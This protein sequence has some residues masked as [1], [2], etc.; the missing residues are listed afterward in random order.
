MERMKGIGPSCLFRASM[1]WMTPFAHVFP[2]PVVVFAPL[3]RHL[4]EIDAISAPTIDKMLVLME[5]PLVQPSAP[6]LTI[7]GELRIPA[8]GWAI[9]PAVPGPQSSVKELLLF[10]SNATRF[11]SSV[12]WIVLASSIWRR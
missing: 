6:A 12:S 2:K 1:L 4:I 10:R 7:S 5:R 9:L 8:A 3:A 11:R